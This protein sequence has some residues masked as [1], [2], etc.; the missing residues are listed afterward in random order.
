L[1]FFSY[2][3]KD[4]KSLFLESNLI[5]DIGGC[6]LAEMLKYNTGLTKLLLSGNSL[7]DLFAGHFAE[8]L[9]SNRTVKSAILDKNMITN[10]GA[11]MLARS[12]S[13]EDNR[14]SSLEC[15]SLNAN[16]RVGNDGAIEFAKAMARGSSL[17]K[18]SLKDCGIGCRACKDLAFIFKRSR[19]VV[20]LTSLDLRQND[21]SAAV[22]SKQF[23]TAFLFQNSSEI[24]HVQLDQ[25][26]ISTCEQYF[27][28]LL[29]LLGMYNLYP[30]QYQQD[31][32]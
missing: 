21:I 1:P 6:A 28:E 32:F 12:V 3:L 19:S 8:A 11:T 17:T 2:I 29:G 23:V 22:V 26:P 10:A 25:N 5:G 13:F 9:L 16:R 7:S 14:E 27:A 30:L 4:L 31:S 15:L 20:R 18:L 24:I